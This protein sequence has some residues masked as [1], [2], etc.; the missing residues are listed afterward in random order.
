MLLMTR[1]G[2]AVRGMGT[3]IEASP[4][5]PSMIVM[6]F[7]MIAGFSIICFSHTPSGTD[8]VSL[9][10][11]V[12]IWSRVCRVWVEE[13][14]RSGTEDDLTEAAHHAVHD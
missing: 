9:P 12:G 14:V 11:P 5:R 13:R 2:R 8:T 3:R 6:T 7:A 10:R 4:G 1:S